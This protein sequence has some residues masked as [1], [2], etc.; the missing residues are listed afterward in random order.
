[1]HNA[2]VNDKLPNFEFVVFKFASLDKLS[3][4]EKDLL[5]SIDPDLLY[6]I[7][8]TA[9]FKKASPGSYCKYNNSR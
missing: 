1:M 5:I 9:K 3:E 6:N 2:I 8:S 7:N 4:L